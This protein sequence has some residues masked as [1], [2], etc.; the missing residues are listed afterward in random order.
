M[1]NN[2]GIGNSKP[3]T[4]LLGICL[5]NNNISINFNR[6]LRLC[7]FRLTHTTYKVYITYIQ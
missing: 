1:K 5:M 3:P 4:I 6:R 7:N 2:S